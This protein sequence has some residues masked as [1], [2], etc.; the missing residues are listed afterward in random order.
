MSSRLRSLF[1]P[2]SAGVLVYNLAVIVW[3]AYVRATG[4]GAGCGDHWPTCDGQVIPR[5]RDVAMLIEF[6]HRVTSG[7][8]LVL[9]LAMVLMAFR[10]YEK[11]HPAR[12]GAGLSGVF[13]LTEALLGAGLV[14]FRL[15]AGDTSMMRAWAH[16]LHLINTFALVAV[17]TLSA[18][19]GYGRGTLSTKGRRGVAYALGGALVATLLLVLTGGIAAL[20]DTLFPSQTLREGL[21]MDFNPSAHV[22]LRLRLWHPVVAIT[23]GV[24]LNVVAWGAYRARRRRLTWWLAAGLTAI[25]A[26]QLALGVLNVYLL[27]PV[28][29]QLA[30]LAI[31]DVVWVLLVLLTCSALE[32][33]ESADVAAA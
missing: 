18:W 8:A 32:V 3:G 24:I 33:E 17:L 10:G 22:L 9:V 1:G 29:L 11:G 12:L 4:S 28:W 25:F 16:G 31:A 23:V 5:P 21:A 26:A 20:G 30:H 19:W 27:A 2:F 14:L 7:L 6:T 15:V 13:I